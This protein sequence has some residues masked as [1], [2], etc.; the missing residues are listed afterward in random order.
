MSM[1]N[2]ERD[3]GE[4]LSR[5]LTAAN[6]AEFH[7][8]VGAIL[9]QYNEGEV[10]APVALWRILK[11]HALVRKCNLNLEVQRVLFPPSQSK[12]GGPDLYDVS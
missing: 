6:Y 1:S 7:P 2:A 4:F 9:R 3:A 10:L 5:E 11:L 8:E 12:I